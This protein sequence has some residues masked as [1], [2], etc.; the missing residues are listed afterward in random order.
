MNRT[1]KI[2]I[3]LTV[4]IVLTAIAAVLLVEYRNS[5]GTKFPFSQP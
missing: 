3:L 5:L 1:Q 4:L 2:A